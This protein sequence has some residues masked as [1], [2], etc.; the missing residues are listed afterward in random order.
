MVEHL[1]STIVPGCFRCELG[2]DEAKDALNYETN[3]WADLLHHAEQNELSVGHDDYGGD[4]EVPQDDLVA[5][6]H[7]ALKGRGFDI[8][9]LDKA[10]DEDVVHDVYDLLSRAREARI[11]YIITRC[12]EWLHEHSLDKN[13]EPIT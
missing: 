6:L 11:T 12:E 5:I 9:V 3:E 4:I 2:E 8:D 13:Q 10:A 1:H 7:A